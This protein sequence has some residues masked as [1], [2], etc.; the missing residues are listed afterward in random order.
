[1]LC[2]NNARDI[3]KLQKLQNRCLRLCFDIYNPMEIGSVRL[4]ELARV[5]MLSTRRDI[6]LLNLM[7]SLN[8]K[9]MYKRDSARVSCNAGRFEF[10]TEIVY[11]DIYS[12]S[13]IYKGV[14]LWNDIPIEHQNLT[15]SKMFKNII[16]KHFSKF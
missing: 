8:P 9:C 14:C 16:K 7:F 5:E 3:D 10:K 15:D 12:K 2:L 6:Q 13:P 11:T 4:H 1:M